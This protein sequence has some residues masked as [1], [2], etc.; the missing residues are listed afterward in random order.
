VVLGHALSVD[1]EQ[2]LKRLPAGTGRLPPF[3]IPTLNIAY[4]ECCT[5]Y[6]VMLKIHFTPLLL[7]LLLSL[8]I[9]LHCGALA[10]LPLSPCLTGP[11][12]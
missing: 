9:S 6:I 1:Y 10:F 8:H 11:V 3:T 12:D 4:T 5:H 7:A 2:D